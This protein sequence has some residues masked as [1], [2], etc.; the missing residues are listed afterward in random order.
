MN[1]PNL[2]NK[3]K[4]REIFAELNLKGESVSPQNKKRR[5]NRKNRRL[6]QYGAIINKLSNGKPL[7][8]TA[9]EKI[10]KENMD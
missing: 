8:P 3:Q 5:K 6:K 9:L 10:L 2:Q 7:E 4:I 1:E